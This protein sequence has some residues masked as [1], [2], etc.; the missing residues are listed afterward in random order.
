MSRKASNPNYVEFSK[1][2]TV[3]VLADDRGQLR[4]NQYGDFFLRKFEGERFT[5]ASP[6]LERQ[7]LD[8][9]ARA[10]MTIGIT[11]NGYNGSTVWKVRLL[12]EPISTPREH[13][14][15]PNHPV[16]RPNGAP[17][18]PAEKFAPSPANENLEAQL[19]ASIAHVQAE[20]AAPEAQEA[21]VNDLLTRCA[22]AA[23]DAAK[24]AEAYAA[25]HGFPLKFRED[26]IQA[27]ASALYIQSSKQSNIRLMARN[28]ELRNGRHS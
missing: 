6:E 24:A 20:R 18:L 4:T 3:V 10:G 28:E 23:I 5:C 14:T 21:Q 15:W 8:S 17:L 25:A 13:K 12:S 19:A 7:I 2:E 9:G 1:S 27:W 22:I 11:R 16:K 26:Q